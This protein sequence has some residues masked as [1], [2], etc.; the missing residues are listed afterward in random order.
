MT[1]LEGSLFCRASM[2]IIIYNGGSGGS[3]V[4][5]GMKTVSLLMYPMVGTG[6]KNRYGS[7]NVAICVAEG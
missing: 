6:N 5:W 2:F 4:T 7:G 3:I 1:Y